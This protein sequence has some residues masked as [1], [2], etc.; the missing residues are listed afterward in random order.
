MSF[1]G[2]PLSRLLIDTFSRRSIFCGYNQLNLRQNKVYGA[3]TCA[4]QDFA[5]FYCVDVEDPDI[6]GDS[7]GM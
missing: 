1:P 4:D 3:F 6:Q 2:L 5:V 7:G